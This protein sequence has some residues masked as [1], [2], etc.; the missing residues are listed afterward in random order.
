MGEK[1]APSRRVDWDALEP[2][3]RAGI[4]ALKDIGKQFEVSDAAILK[5]A[6]KNGWTRNLKAKIQAKADA[7]VSAAMVSAEVSALTKVTEAVTVE[8]EA[9]VQSRIRL[10]HRQDIGRT[11]SLFRTLLEEVE[12][13]SSAEGQRLIEALGEI[14]D[15]PA[16]EESPE[17]ARK[18]ADRMQRALSKVLDG[19]ARI[20]S[21]KKLTETLEK[22]VRLEREAYG[23][24]E[25][26]RGATGYEDMLA[27]ALN[28]PD[29]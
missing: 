8:V 19:P 14:V 2:H 6:K 16:D 7:K 5:H 28:E 4:R 1:K 27:K 9:E 18:R 3:Y 20:E 24:N 26:G 10:S 11:R 13:A 22:L 15:K 17:D 29:A 25:G 21:A 23:L 12:V